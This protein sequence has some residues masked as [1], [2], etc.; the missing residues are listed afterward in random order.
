MRSFKK[1]LAAVSAVT[2]AFGA[3][4]L[5]VGA[6]APNEGGSVNVSDLG[7]FVEGGYLRV[8]FTSTD[9]NATAAQIA[10]GFNDE[11]KTEDK[12]TTIG[13]HYGVAADAENT[14]YTDFTYEEISSYNIESIMPQNW[15]AWINNEGVDVNLTF[16]DVSWI[17]PATPAEPEGEKLA[18]WENTAKSV[19]AKDDLAKA[20]GKYVATYTS[21]SNDT[22]VCLVFVGED[23]WDNVGATSKT[24]VDGVT[25]VE[26]SYADIAAAVALKGYDIADITHVRLT[27]A[28]ENVV[29]VTSDPTY[30]PAETITATPVGSRIIGTDGYVAD[31]YTFDVAA[32]N[33]VKVVVTLPNVPGK[34][35]TSGTLQGAATF[36]LIIATD[37]AEKLDA[38]GAPVITIQ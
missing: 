22:N 38:A 31:T 37:S 28:G 7:A 6:V 4:A 17:N 21:E 20:S 36:G 23:I 9:E 24:T 1:M 26:Y 12:W 15:G 30:V 33:A 18:Q 3:M 16:T 34:S 29:Y 2:I 10:I 11:N 35:F 27:N 19:W 8:T 13:G 32:G 14:Y 5:Q 25:T